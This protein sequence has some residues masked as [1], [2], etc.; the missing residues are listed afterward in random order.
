MNRVC[1]CVLLE[2]FLCFG[3]SKREKVYYYWLLETSNVQYTNNQTSYIYIF[4]LIFIFISL[5]VAGTC[6]YRWYRSRFSYISRFVCSWKSST[7]ERKPIEPGQS[8]QQNKRH[9]KT[10]SERCWTG[11]CWS[12]VRWAV[13]GAISRPDRQPERGL[14]VAVWSHV[15][16]FNFLSSISSL[17]STH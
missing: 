11:P 1:V 15:F 6:L 5:H 8:G 16:L 4:V 10:E 7:N 3:M 9:R 13:T 12:T 2:V 14:R 17:Q